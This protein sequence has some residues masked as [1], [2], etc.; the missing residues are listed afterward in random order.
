MAAKI[1]GVACVNWLLL[2]NDSFVLVECI[3]VIRVGV[4]KAYLQ[5]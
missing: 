5:G 3:G 4:K 1:D 2:G